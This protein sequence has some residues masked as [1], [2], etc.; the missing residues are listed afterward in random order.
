MGVVDT[1]NQVSN[2]QPRSSNSTGSP[3]SNCQGNGYDPEITRSNVSFQIL[4][5]WVTGVT[6]H[7]FRNLRR[8]GASGCFPDCVEIM[9]KQCTY[10]NLHSAP[11]ILRDARL[12]T[13]DQSCAP[14]AISIQIALVQNTFSWFQRRLFE[15]SSSLWESLE[16]SRVEL[17]AGD[18]AE[19]G[20][21]RF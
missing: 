10:I 13:V 20:I 9:C 21:P 19:Q 3:Y 4:L 14:D 2:V 12:L 6:T 1:S 11:H 7:E 17:W 15:E 16:S 8:I 5:K 18:E